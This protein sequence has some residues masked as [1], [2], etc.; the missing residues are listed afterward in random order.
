M[1]SEKCNIPKCELEA[2]ARTFLDDVIGFFE[3]EEGKR[4]YQERLSQHNNDT[5]T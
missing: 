3:S 5:L 2:L 4:E 1:V